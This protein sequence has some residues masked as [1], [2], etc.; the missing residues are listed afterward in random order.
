[1]IWLVSHRLRTKI[2]G[3]SKLVEILGFSNPEKKQI[4]EILLLSALPNEESKLTN[5]NDKYTGALTQIYKKYPEKFFSKNFN[6]FPLLIKILCPARDLSLQVHPTDEY[7]Q[8]HENQPYGKEET[9]VCL[10]SEPNQKIIFGHK[11]N[12]L[13]ILKELIQKKRWD[14]II[15]PIKITKNSLVNVIPG[16]VHAVLA[17]TV[18]YELQQNCD[19]TYRLYD[20]DRL[21]DGKLRELNVKKALENI[22]FPQKKV[23]NQKIVYQE[24][25]I[26]LQLQN[27]HYLLYSVHVCKKFE[28]MQIDEC[29]VGTVVEGTCK[30][31]N[32]VKVSKYNTFL[33]SRKSKSGY[34]FVGNAKILFATITVN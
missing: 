13:Q 7:A 19:L 34:E 11:I 17:N 3:S 1:M 25:Q 33:I 29:Y 23:A 32:E 6:S 12:T 14:E 2:W 27:T 9:W 31:N 28:L 24:N 10:S 26:K 30:I 22:Y 20:Y 15:N 18:V 5:V 4:G 8:K 16:T 21:S